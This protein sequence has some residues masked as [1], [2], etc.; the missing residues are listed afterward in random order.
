MFGSYNIDLVSV[1]RVI[2]QVGIERIQYGTNKIKYTWIKDKTDTIQI[3]FR[4][5]SPKFHLVHLPIFQ[6]SFKQHS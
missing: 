5:G 2:S 3:N 4:T 6:E 1:N